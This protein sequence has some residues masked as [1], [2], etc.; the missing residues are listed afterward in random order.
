VIAKEGLLPMNRDFV[1]LS[2]D[3]ATAQQVGARHDTHPVIYRI[4][5]RDAAKNG[6]LFYPTSSRVWL[7]SEL[8][9]RF[10]HHLTSYFRRP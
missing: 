8:P 2:E 3:V 5:A 4:A 9:A 7:V 10:L 6:I 1:H